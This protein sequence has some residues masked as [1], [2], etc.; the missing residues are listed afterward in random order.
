MS[1]IL[2]DGSALNSIGSHFELKLSRDPGQTGSLAPR[3][4]LAGP[5]S[6]G[7]ETK[8]K[9]LECLFFERDSRGR[10]SKQR[11]WRCVSGI[12]I[13]SSVVEL[14]EP[15]KGATT[16]QAASRRSGRHC[17]KGAK[18]GEC[19]FGDAN[20]LALLAF[21][22]G[23]Q[24]ALR[25]PLE[26][27]HSC[28]VEGC[29][30]STTPV[31]RPLSSAPTT[32][33]KRA[34]NIPGREHMVPSRP[35][36]R[37]RRSCSRRC[38]PKRRRRT[39]RWFIDASSTKQHLVPKVRL[40]EGESSL[41]RWGR[42][43]LVPEVHRDARSACRTRVAAGGGQLVRRCQMQPPW[44]C[45]PAVPPLM[46]ARR[47]IL[48][49]CFRRATSTDLF[50][51]PPFWSEHGPRAAGAPRK[52]MLPKKPPCWTKAGRRPCFSTGPSV[53]KEPLFKKRPCFQRRF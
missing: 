28:V 32:P 26:Q 52:P 36:H 17:R 24:R 53:W 34:R 20:E 37:G 16:S 38:A 9:V 31:S 40:R 5:Q 35:S 1:L 22:F 48:P 46:D 4:K 25:P 12:R 10:P 21:T 6:I 11:G 18:N 14:T 13:V 33:R 41:E 42:N 39:R 30:S 19:P 49:P 29:A 8:P 15:A 23:R 47:S 2:S 50:L 27:R 7:S 44:P 3:P 43:T 51:F 45:S